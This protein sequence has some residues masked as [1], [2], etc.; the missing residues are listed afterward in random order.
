MT[1]VGVLINMAFSC[2][3]AYPLSKPYFKGRKFFTNMVI[4]TMLFSGG[5]V[6]AYLVVAKVQF[7]R[8]YTG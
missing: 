2:T 4:V 5:M 1:V 8:D 6:P 7:T 3:L